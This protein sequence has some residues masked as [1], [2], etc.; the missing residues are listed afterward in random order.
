VAPVDVAAEIRK[1]AA[2]RSQSI[3]RIVAF[4]AMAMS[5]CCRTTLTASPGFMWIGLARTSNSG[6]PV[7]WLARAYRH[8][9]SS[10]LAL[11]TAT[12]T[13]GAA[14]PA[15][16]NLLR[17]A[18]TVQTIA[19]SAQRLSWLL[20]PVAAESEL[21]EGSGY[22]PLRTLLHMPGC[23]DDP[24]RTRAGRYNYH[25]AI[26]ARFSERLRKVIADAPAPHSRQYQ[27]QD[28]GID[29]RAN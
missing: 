9:R 16:I 1:K 27:S 4:A 23:A 15:A 10:R 6:Q 5:S 19:E 17:A 8:T 18:N 20:M 13:N 28:L 14:Y 24:P 12:E 3:C 26:V 22:P 7:V 11:R 25:S 2:T 29:E 21:F